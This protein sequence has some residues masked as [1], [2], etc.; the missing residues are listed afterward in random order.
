MSVVEFLTGTEWSPKLEGKFGI[1]PLVSGT[2]LVT[3]LRHIYL[4]RDVASLSGRVPCP[5]AIAPTNLLASASDPRT[6][7]VRVGSPFGLAFDADRNEIVAYTNFRVTAEPTFLSYGFIGA[8][9]VPI[10]H[11]E[12]PRPL[13]QQPLG[14]TRE[15]VPVPG[16]GTFGQPAL[17]RYDCAGDKATGVIVNTVATGTYIFR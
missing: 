2:L 14:V 8:F 16:F 17:F 3:T 13:W 10:D 11:C 4:F 5:A 15:G 9:S 12:V 1:L 6:S 7:S